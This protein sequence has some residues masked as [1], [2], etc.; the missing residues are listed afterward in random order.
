LFPAGVTAITAARPRLLQSS[1]IEAEEPVMADVKIAVIN[2]STIIKDQDVPPVV[3]ALQKQVTRDFAPVWGCPAD[4]RLVPRGQSA[5]ANEWQLVIADD[6]DQA[7]ALGYHQLTKN[8][9]PLGFV[10][11]RTAVT[12]NDSWTVTASHE[13]LEML[14]DPNI[15]LTVFDQGEV[16]ARLY[17]YEVCDACEADKFG[18][19]IDGVLVSDFVYPAWF[20]GFWQKNEVQFDF[21]KHIQTPF[22]LLEDGY[23]GINDIVRGIGW[24]QLEAR[25]TQPNARAIPFQGSRRQRRSV[26]VPDRIR[27]TV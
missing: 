22:E 16:G 27:S 19:K 1:S 15:N 5:A 25:A 21:G 6:A 20:E 13:L 14:G 2:V 17:A 9:L 8:G 23:I 11:A 26:P 7:G 24:Y 10:F 3:A 12:H 18:Y 4:L